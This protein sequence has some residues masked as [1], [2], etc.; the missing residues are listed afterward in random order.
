VIRCACLLETK[1]KAIMLVRVRDND[2]WYLPG[3]TI[4]DGETPPDTLIREIA[5]ELNVRIDE[6]S[7]GFERV[8]VGPALGRAGDV[9]LNCFR[10]RWA[11]DMRATAEVSEV[12]YLGFDQRDRM[13]PAVRILVE[14]LQSEL[15]AS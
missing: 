2:L 10:A 8:V 14:Q 12:A 3:G 5:E 7:V 11:G 6:A 15:A 13:A 9:E 4:E 1:D